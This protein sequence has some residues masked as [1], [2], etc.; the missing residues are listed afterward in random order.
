MSD[1]SEEYETERAKGPGARVRVK[2]CEISMCGKE[3]ETASE[4]E[5]VL[6]SM[7]IEELT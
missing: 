2:R 1:L 4:D 7:Q 5:M 6:T 3:T